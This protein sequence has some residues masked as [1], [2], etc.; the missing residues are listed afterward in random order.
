MSS[1]S[2]VSSSAQSVE[3]A[4]LQRFTFNALNLY[5]IDLSSGVTV[6]AALSAYRASPNGTPPDV[7][8]QCPPTFG[9]TDIWLG[10]VSY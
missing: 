2:P 6:S 7:V 10:T 8:A 3:T 5:E 9:N 4:R 1:L